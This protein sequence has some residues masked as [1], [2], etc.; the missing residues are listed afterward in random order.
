[1][2]ALGLRAAASPTAPQSDKV[3]MAPLLAHV[4]PL[5]PIPLPSSS[6]ETPG[7]GVVRWRAGGRFSNVSSYNFSVK[8]P[9]FASSFYLY[10]A[11]F[12]ELLPSKMESPMPEP[13]SEP[14][15]PDLLYER[16]RT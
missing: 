6:T 11:N 4:I 2:H 12:R 3:V 16:S 7:N 5:K 8:Y 14:P 13:H 9:L 10:G 1:M 15:R